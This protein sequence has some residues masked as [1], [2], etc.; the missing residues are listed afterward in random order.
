MALI[1]AYR[2]AF[3]ELAT[4]HQWVDAFAV[5]LT[6]KPQS[7]RQHTQNFRH[8]M[9]RLNTG[10]LGNAFGRYG[11]QLSV[12]AVIEGDHRD[13][14]HYHCVIDNPRREQ[15]SIFVES[16]EQCWNDTELGLPE[17]SITPDADIVWFRYMAKIR[18]KDEYYDAFDWE[19]AWLERQR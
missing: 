10:I 17:N 14:P 2:E 5:T 15:R 11:R 8:F 4:N 6:M 9:N 13:H 18:D 19:N 1:R 16:I 3:I 7:W 12:L